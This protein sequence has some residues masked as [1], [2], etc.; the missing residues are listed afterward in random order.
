MNQGS[1]LSMVK[2]KAQGNVLF[3]QV[4]TVSYQ[5]LLACHGG[6][7]RKGRVIGGRSQLEMC[8]GLCAVWSSP[9]SCG[10]SEFF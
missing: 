6:L 1:L 2:G 9:E 7:E 3:A 8:Y 10:M 4:R 5:F